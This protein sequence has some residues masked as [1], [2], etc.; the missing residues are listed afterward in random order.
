M[1]PSATQEE[2]LKTD[3]AATLETDID[4]TIA[5]C[6]GDPRA[7]VGALLVMIRS[8]RRMEKQGDERAADDLQQ[9]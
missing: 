5:A 9:L 6:D 3:S 1:T 4:E 7:A 8:S 2:R